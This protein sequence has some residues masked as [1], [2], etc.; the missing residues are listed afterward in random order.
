MV[1]SLEAQN[2]NKHQ[3]Y[4]NFELPSSIR[5][6]EKRRKSFVACCVPVS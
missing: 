2:M 3:A 5:P 6:I 1:T 4:F